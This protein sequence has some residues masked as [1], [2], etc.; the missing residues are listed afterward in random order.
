[1]F[2]VDLKAAKDRKIQRQLEQKRIA[3]EYQRW[4]MSNGMGPA[5]AQRWAPPDV[6]AGL[7]MINQENKQAQRQAAHQ[8]KERIKERF[9]VQGSGS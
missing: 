5:E 9:S 4:A 1:M 7:G 2:G 8:Q 6:K 3:R